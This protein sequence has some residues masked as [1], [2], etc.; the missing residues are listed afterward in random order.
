MYQLTEINVYPIKSLRGF[1][2]QQAVVEPRG[3]QYDRRWMLVDTAGKFVSQREIAAMT[4]LKTAI[5]SSFLEIYAQQDPEN[6]L[7]ISLVPE[8]EAME[9]RQVNIWDDNCMASIYPKN[10]N[11]W[12]SAQLGADLCLVYMSDADQRQADEMYAPK[13]QYVS[14][15]DGF[16]YLL[17]GE[18][19]LTDLNQRLAEPIPMNRF[20][21]NLVFSGGD[22]YEE[23]QW[24]DFRIGSITFK[25]VKPCGRCI[26]TTTDQETGNRSKEPLK[27]LA[28]YRQQNNRILFGQNVILTEAQAGAIIRT[29]D[30]L[31]RF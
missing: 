29:G 5:T 25:G 11:D 13:G 22:A 2:V 16:P 28:N 17:I 15:A 31:Q 18:A 3:L 4:Q 6:R 9:K 7:Q 21:P 30:P 23:D 26:I 27:T 19:S 14:F 1:S 8:L 24:S 10:V 12:F 20:R